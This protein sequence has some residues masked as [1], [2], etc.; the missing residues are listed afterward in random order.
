M[1]API[2]RNAEWLERC[3]Q[4]P[5]SLPVARSTIVELIDEVE[6]CWDDID[7]HESEDDLARSV[8]A[9]YK[10]V[11]KALVDVLTQDDRH[12]KFYCAP[13]CWTQNGYACICGRAERQ[14]RYDIAMTQAKAL[15]KP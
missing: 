3:K 5:T 9:D 10:R 11:L 2:D 13:E 12:G 6:K 1:S 14:A 4:L 15:V 7:L 8:L